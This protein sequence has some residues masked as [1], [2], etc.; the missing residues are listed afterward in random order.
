MARVRYLNLHLPS[1]L[2]GEGNFR[3]TSSEFELDKLEAINKRSKHLFDSFIIEIASDGWKV[4]QN[5]FPPWNIVQNWSK[6][7]VENWSHFHKQLGE[8]I[9]GTTYS[10]SQNSCVMNFG[11]GKKLPYSNPHSFIFDVCI[12]WNPLKFV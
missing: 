3:V 12:V 6:L 1:T 5:K 7:L 8:I 10:F 11:S 2:L 9:F 4:Q